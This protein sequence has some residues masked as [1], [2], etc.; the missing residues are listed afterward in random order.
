MGSYVI[1]DKTPQDA[2]TNDKVL[3][4]YINEESMGKVKQG[5]RLVGQIA[6]NHWTPGLT[7]KLL[8]GEGSKSLEVDYKF[9][10]EAKKT[11]NI[12]SLVN[13]N[14]D[15]LRLAIYKGLDYVHGSSYIPRPTRALIQGDV[16]EKHS[17]NSFNW[18]LD[19]IC[20]SGINE[21][22]LESFFFDKADGHIAES[23][24]DALVAAI[25]NKTEF[26]FDRK[27]SD[28]S[29]IELDCDRIIAVTYFSNKNTKESDNYGKMGPTVSMSEAIGSSGNLL[30]I[31]CH[32][33]ETEKAIKEAGDTGNHFVTVPDHWVGKAPN[34]VGNNGDAVLSRG[35]F[36]VSSILEFNGVIY[37]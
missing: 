5:E 14:E 35:G 29:S 18:K 6:S 13:Y 30:A 22:S 25:E 34:D 8:L 19:V 33:P 37:K 2:N 28:G 9:K 4:L 23:F 11:E 10:D 7:V 36:C 31:Y 24:K 26:S 32:S 1:T 20:S 16:V 21:A 12:Y 17:P 15:H 27:L 3:S